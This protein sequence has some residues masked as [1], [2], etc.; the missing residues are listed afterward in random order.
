M[1]TG[2][3]INP[4]EIEFPMKYSTFEALNDFGDASCVDCVD[5]QVAGLDNNTVRES[6]DDNAY[7]T[8]YVQVNWDFEEEG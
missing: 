1:I 4:E 8:D 6:A 5:I 3:K 2:Y 7:A